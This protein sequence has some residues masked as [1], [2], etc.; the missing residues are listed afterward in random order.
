MKYM[1]ALLTAAVLLAGVN[2]GHAAVRIT[3]DRGG[4]ISDYLDKF[5]GLRASGQAVVI[6]GLCASACTMVLGAVP[7][8]KI[9]V[10]PNAT[11]AFHAAFNFIGGGRT[12]TNPEA[13][14]LLYSQ[15]PRPVQRW[16][17][18]R[19]GLT[20]HMM[21]L[22]GRELEAMYRPCGSDARFAAASGES[23]G[24]L[25]SS[26]SGFGA[27]FMRSRPRAKRHRF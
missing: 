12:M 6:D 2:A 16:I 7:H 15:Y 10:T 19:G 5:D 1:Y 17:N 20:P 8:D 25:S 22:R 14:E 21:F 23:R 18:N 24:M 4:L 26:P 13:T 11:L 9:C 27:A 3:N